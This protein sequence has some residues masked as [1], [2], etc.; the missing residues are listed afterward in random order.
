LTWVAFLLVAFAVVGLV[1][2]FASYAAPIPL[3]REA[4]REAALDA[5]LAAAQDRPALERL[6]PALDDSADAVL[7]GTGP[8]AARVA[9]ERQSMRLR[10]QAQAAALGVRLRWM[11]ALIALTA[12]GFGVAVLYISQS[13]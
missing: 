1:G 3:A 5:V 8:I 11:I 2:V 13:R 7:D 12:A 6:R 9:A 4:G 10:F